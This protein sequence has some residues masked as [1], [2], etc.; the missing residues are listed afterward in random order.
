MR[1]NASPK[2]VPASHN[3]HASS[4]PLTHRQLVELLARARQTPRWRRSAP[5]TPAG[6]ALSNGR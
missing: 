6:V 2:S 3:R 5:Q 1:G 4:L